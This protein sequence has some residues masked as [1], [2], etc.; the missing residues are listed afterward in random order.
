MELIYIIIEKEVAT[1]RR[2][3]VEWCKTYAAANT[4]AAELNAESPDYVHTV[5]QLPGK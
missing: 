5:G 2:N 1:G 3:P 4:R